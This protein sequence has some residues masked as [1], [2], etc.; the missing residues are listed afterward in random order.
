MW[1]CV[2]SR[3]EGIQLVPRD[4]TASQFPEDNTIW[5]VQGKCTMVSK[6]LKMKNN[7]IFYYFLGG[8]YI[9]RL[10]KLP[11]LNFIHT[12]CSRSLSDSHLSNFKYSL[13]EASAA[14]SIT[15]EYGD[16]LRSIERAWNTNIT[17][18][19]KHAATTLH[20]LSESKT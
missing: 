8:T 16:E 10:T 11:W 17:K 1:K 9:N 14:K 12:W 13:L 20:S 5:R 19:Y 2:E 15:K 18:K 3:V 4:S 6:L 7:H